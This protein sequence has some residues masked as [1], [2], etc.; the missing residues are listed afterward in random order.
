MNTFKA[1]FSIIFV[2]G[3]IVTIP[4]IQASET[5]VAITP[6]SETLLS[7]SLTPQYLLFNTPKIGASQN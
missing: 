6:E 7:N 1:M 5:T 4:I 2:I 3:M